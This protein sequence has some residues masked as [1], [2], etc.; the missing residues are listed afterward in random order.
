MVPLMRPGTGF[1]AASG[2]LAIL[3]PN[4]MRYL[5]FHDTDA[6]EVLQDF[7]K[8]IYGAFN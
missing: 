8:R 7:E 6:I 4:W 3:S 1:L 5:P 2:L